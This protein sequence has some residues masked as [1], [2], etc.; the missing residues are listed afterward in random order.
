MKGYC[1]NSPSKCNNAAVFELVE[2]ED[3]FCPECQRLLISEGCHSP[4]WQLTFDLLHGVLLLL[5]VVVSAAILVI[6]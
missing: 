5:V 3:E 2:S 1:S 4:N 6:F